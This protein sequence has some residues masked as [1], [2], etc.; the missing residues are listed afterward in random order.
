MA[1]FLRRARPPGGP[2]RHRHDPRGCEVGDRR[3]DGAAHHA[4]IRTL[5]QKL[6][7]FLRPIS[8]RATHTGRT[9]PVL[10]L[11]PQMQPASPAETQRPRPAHPPIA[12]PGTPAEHSRADA[13][14]QRALPAPNRLERRKLRAPIR[15]V[16]SRVHRRHDGAHSVSGLGR[17]KRRRTRHLGSTTSALRVPGG[18]TTSRVLA[19]PEGVS[20]V[21]EVSPT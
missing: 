17:R 19:L 9:L 7:V 12:A 16:A 2:R 11:A 6:A 15:G 3:A 18:T 4:H 21:L 20:L 13:D 10:E 8:V 1:I 14:P 5:L